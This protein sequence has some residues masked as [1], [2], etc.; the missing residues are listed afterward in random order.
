MSVS[1]SMITEESSRSTIDLTAVADS[2][3]T[4]YSGGIVDCIKDA[5]ISRPDAVAGCSDEF[6]TSG[7]TRIRLKVVYGIG[8]LLSGVCRQVTIFAARA[9]FQL[10]LIHRACLFSGYSL[11]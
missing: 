6:F 8:Y 4:H 2:I 9:R 10:D 1:H 7:W 5:V 11:A 3:N